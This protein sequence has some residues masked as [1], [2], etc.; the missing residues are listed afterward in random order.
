[1]FDRTNGSTHELFSIAPERIACDFGVT[2]DVPDDGKHHFIVNG[3]YID[4]DYELKIPMTFGPG[5]QLTSADTIKFDLSGEGFVNSLD[6][7]TLWINYENSL[8]TAIDLDVLFLDEYNNI[9][10]SIRK[11]FH[12]NAA[13][14]SRATT[15]ELFDGNPA[16]G[17]FTL[18]FNKNEI[19]DAQK[20]RYVI[21]KSTLKTSGNEDVNIHPKDYIN[22]KLSAYSKV[23][24]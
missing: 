11:N 5:T 16:T 2:L 19:D 1:M 17:L 14:S 6:E 7:L 8:R 22:F 21:L 18:K 24:I 4:I 9:I 15:K 13:P 20:A 3:K 10:P 23:N 12:I